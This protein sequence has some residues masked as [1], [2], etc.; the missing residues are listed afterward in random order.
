M[1]ALLEKHREKFAAAPR[2]AKDVLTTGLSPAPAGD[3]VELAA[4]TSVVRVF[5]NLH[6]TITRN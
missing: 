3:A 2:R 1:E 4:W 6:E 5:L